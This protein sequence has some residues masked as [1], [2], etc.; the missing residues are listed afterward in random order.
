MNYWRITKYNPEFR[1]SN[2]IYQKDEW[3]S[4]SDI[5]KIFNGK[6][7]Q[8]QE[9]LTVE[10][11]YL[12]AILQFIK[13]MNIPFIEINDLE[14]NE[15]D[16]EIINKYAEIYPDEI[17]NTYNTINNRSIIMLDK[18]EQICIL[19]LR[20]HIWLKLEYEKIL[21]IHFGY[22]YYMYFG[23]DKKNDSFIENIKNSGLFI[24]EYESPYLSES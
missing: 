16:K 21:F 18:L 15:L 4:F 17:I 13:I 7:L 14:K 11:L 9:Y 3:T 12:N 5:N 24:E 6:K 10:K 1:D 22:D 8:L 19:T 23:S 2:N 20:E